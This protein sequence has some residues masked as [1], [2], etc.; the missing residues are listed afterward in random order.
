MSFIS[1]V[2]THQLFPVITLIDNK[3]NT[4]VELYAFGS[5]LNKFEFKVGGE[6]VNIVD[7]FV[8][9]QEAIS[10]MTPAF[11]SAFLSPFTCRMNQGKYQFDDTAYQIEKFFLP[12]HAIHGLVFDAMFTVDKVESTEDFAAVQL[13]YTY[14]KEDD[15]YPF[16]YT[17]THYWKLERGNKLTV[18]S[19]VTHNNTH[20]IPYAQGWHPYFKLGN[21][22][23]ECLLQFSADRQVEFDE[24]LLPS[25]NIIDDERFTLGAN[26]A[27]INLDN[28][29]HLS[30]NQQP[31]CVLSNQSIKLVIEPDASYP[32][33]QVYTPPHRKSIAI[34]NLSGAPDCFNNKMGL[35]FIEPQSCSIFTTSFTATTL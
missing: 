13:S 11:K 30:P 24:T 32:F 2:D 1:V 18:A 31:V 22:I 35:H 5:V 3:V 12:P 23:D 27:G 7:G 17:V 21:T 9:P 10:Q 26:L 15:G 14:N 33:L 28:C 20:A 34:E 25:G 8:S 6:T 29:F 4:S 19:T 16:S